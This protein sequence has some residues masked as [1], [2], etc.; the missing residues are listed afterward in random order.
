MKTENKLKRKSE[1]PKNEENLPRFL[2]H[3]VLNDN[4]N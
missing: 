4:S 3:H 1:K 2:S